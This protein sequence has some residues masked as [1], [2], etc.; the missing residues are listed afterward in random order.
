M[1]RFDDDPCESQEHVPPTD[2]NSS[3]LC[4]SSDGD[5]NEGDC[6]RINIK[7]SHRDNRAAVVQ[8]KSMHLLS[9]AMLPRRRFLAQSVWGVAGAVWMTETMGGVGGSV[10]WGAQA[11]SSESEP[12][13]FQTQFPAMG[14]LLR[15]LWEDSGPTRAEAAERAKGVDREGRALAEY[16]NGLLSDYDDESE[17][18]RLS[19]AADDLQWHP[20]SEDLGRVLREADRWYRLSEG[21]FDA[22]LGAMTRLRRKRKLPAST[23]WERAKESIGWEWVDWDGDRGRLRFKRPG[24]RFDFGAI[25]KGWVAD[26]I[27]DLLTGKDL[28]RC[29]INF[30]GN[31]RIG[32]P[33]SNATGWPVSIDACSRGGATEEPVEL[34][35][36]SLSQCG[37][38]TSGDRWQRLPDARSQSRSETSSHILDPRLGLG[39]DAPQSITI[40]APDATSAD[41]A[42]TA[43]GVQIH[44]NASHWLERLSESSPDYRWIIQILRANEIHLMQN[45]GE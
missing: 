27:F 20:V 21:A 35:R 32:N 1:K 19:A 9:C 14:S 18:S 30:A 33:P 15:I 41:A 25:G 39:L 12:A 6:F 42:S 8:N 34:V 40:L 38:S 26:R 28:D 17:A 31:M 23:D 45:S 36:L 16:W 44:R 5:P 22:S 10:L 3:M 43:T 4:H 13:S 2:R 11:P 29:L 7:G 24:I 37:I